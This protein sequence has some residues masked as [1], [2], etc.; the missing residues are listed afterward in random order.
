[1]P[2]LVVGPMLRYVDE[3]SAS[4]WVETS[5]PC[6]VTIEV[7]GTRSRASTFTV[8]GHHYA[9]VDVEG[10]GAYEV[11]LGEET[12]WPLPDQAPSRIRL[13]DPD[14]PRR[15]MFGSCR[16][17]VPHDT[18]H[19]ISHGVD[20]LRAYGRQPD[21]QARGGAARPGAPARRPGLRRRAV[22]RDAGVHQDRRDDEPKTEIADFE[23]YAELYRL[24]WTDPEIRWLLSTVPSAMIF[25]DHDLRDDLNTSAL[26]AR[27]DGRR[28]SW[29]RA[30][31]T[32]ALGAYWIYQHLGNMSPA[33]ALGGRAARQAAREGGRRGRGPRHVRQARRRRPDADNRWSYSRDL[34]G[35]RLLMLDSRCRAAAR[36]PD[37]RR[38]LDPVEWEWLD[39]ELKKEGASALCRH[40]GA[41][42]AALRHPPHRELERGAVRTGPGA[43]GRRAGAEKIRQ[44]VD[45]EHWGAFRRS[46]EEL[47]RLLVG[48]R[49]SP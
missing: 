33:G 14:G 18:M 4:V 7:G 35:T 40:V 8:H 16:T 39:G 2:E 29:W 24:A 43:E 47:S 25:D 32:S 34:G 1:M 17:S 27:A 28:S 6:E 36:P 11:R 23:E 38:M 12:V 10:G 26:L 21:G 22:R 46:F 3:T 15:V 41:V 19:T 45:L 13:L 37:D 9:I 30:A 44:A 20:V 49:A 42:P 48:G 5:E 31:V